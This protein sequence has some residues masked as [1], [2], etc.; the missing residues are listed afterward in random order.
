[1]GYLYQLTA[2]HLRGL[3][4]CLWNDGSAEWNG[5]GIQP[6]NCNFT[7]RIQEENW[8]YVKRLL[9]WTRTFTDMWP[10]IYLDVGETPVNFEKF[11][12]TSFYRTAL[13]D[14]FWN[15]YHAVTVF[16]AYVRNFLSIFYFFTK[17]Y[18]FKNHEKCFFILYKKL[19]SFS[20]YSN[21]C[22]IF[23]SFPH[24]PDSKGQMEVE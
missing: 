8:T 19:I 22:D 20:R 14:W 10:W 15:L 13:N 1:M 2:N 21:F 7:R 6:P 11:L 3:H 24:F 23:P 5:K 16:K 17:W 9:D 12:E 18:P 4:V